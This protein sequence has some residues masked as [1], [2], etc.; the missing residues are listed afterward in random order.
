[1]KFGFFK[2]KRAQ[3]SGFWLT[4]KQ[5]GREFFLAAT[6]ATAW[7]A[8][9]FMSGDKPLTVVQ[10]VN[11][12]GPT[13]F[14][15]AWMTGNFV[16][17]KKQSADRAHFARI[18]DLLTGGDSY[19]YVSTVSDGLG[20]IVSLILTVRGKNS[21]FDL[22]MTVTD[23][24]KKVGVV[25]RNPT[26]N[27]SEYQTRYQ[28]GTMGSSYYESFH[29]L[30]GQAIDRYDFFIYTVARN[31]RFEQELKLQ[32]VNGKWCMATRITKDSVL[33]NEYIQ[34]NFPTPVWPITVQ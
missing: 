21:L 15:V 18:T 34:P 16:R 5:Y 13:F 19:P 2:T 6:I 10:A 22:T 17:I 31:G 28:F 32:R 12:F 9:S 1:M 4:L 33:L 30:S 14:I 3:M 11:I 23:L 27:G 8:Y 29:S 20:N 26:S 25:Q 7:T 24:I